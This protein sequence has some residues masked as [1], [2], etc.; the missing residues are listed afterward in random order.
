LLGHRLR[1]LLLRLS[2]LLLRL[3]VQHTALAPLDFL[4][5]SA[6]LLFLSH[7]L[8]RLWY[9]RWADPVGAK[10]ADG[11]F[12]LCYGGF[13]CG[14]Q[15]QWTACLLGAFLFIAQLAVLAVLLWVL[16]C[17]LEVCGWW[18]VGTWTVGSA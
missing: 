16:S 4:L 6:L 2:E 5:L 1:T 10:V 12:A 13:I 18:T 8:Q 7:G 15:C 14:E 11:S 3:H 9:A 17:C